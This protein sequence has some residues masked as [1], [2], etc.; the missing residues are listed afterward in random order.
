ML[1]VDV[2]AVILI[3][4]YFWYM[5]WSSIQSVPQPAHQPIHAKPVSTILTARGNH[6]R[7]E[8]NH[9]GW[10]TAMPDDYVLHDDKIVQQDGCHG[11]T[12][13]ALVPA[14]GQSLYRY[15][16]RDQ[17]IQSLQPFQSDAS[18]TLQDKRVFYFTCLGGQIHQLHKCPPGQI[19]QNDRCQDIN[20]CV[21]QP[22]GTLL[23]D[24]F[25]LSVYYV[26]RRG[27]AII[28]KCDSHEFFVNDQCMDHDLYHYCKHDQEPRI[29]SHDTMLICRRGHVSYETCPPGYR[30]FDSPK[31]ESD[32]CVGQPD[33]RR[34]PLPN[35][36]INSIEYAPG[37]MSCKANKVDRIQ[38]CPKYW[39][40]G[41]DRLPF[42]PQVFNGQECVPPELC[43]NVV[44]TDPDITMPVFE[45]TKDVRNWK[46]ASRFDQVTGIV[47]EGGAR[48]RVAMDPGRRINKRLKQESACD[49]E[50][51]VVVS[52]KTNAYYDC[53]TQAVVNCPDNHFFNGLECKERNPHAFKYNG[54]DMF[55]M[56]SLSPD[57][58]I[59]PWDYYGNKNEII[60]TCKNPDLILN[61]N[62]NVC[63][64]PDCIHFP[65]LSQ[66]DFTIGLKDG[67]ECEYQ[68][69]TREIIKIQTDKQ[70]LFWSQRQV[71]DPSLEDDCTPNQN[72]KSG[73]FAFDKT[74]FA[75]C[76]E[77]QP[78][79]FCPSSDTDG[80]DNVSKRWVC[81]AQ[82]MAYFV[83]PHTKRNYIKNEAYKITREKSAS[84]YINKLLIPI[85]EDGLDVSTYDQIELETRVRGVDVHVRRVTHPPDVAIRKGGIA[86][87]PNTAYLMKSDGFTKKAL[88]FPKYSVKGCVPDFLLQT[89]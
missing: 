58:W 13:D 14:V 49:T 10:E 38:T 85:P 7:F 78:F 88:N 54:L 84:V 3:L 28:K 46:W 35:E 68:E 4:L 73:H 30:Y 53:A 77:S 36:S 39:G 47:C 57:N 24:A 86:H 89:R 11:Q 51:R 22:D 9:T 69:S 62:Y 71:D 79:V 32:A 61:T 16:Q 20:L 75:T 67:S 60:D 56:D 74:I 43:T 17:F 1:L 8:M 66:I 25:D 80:I 29:L 23:N 5:T 59:K 12:D 15:L 34:L 76:D 50:T 40:F 33:G 19:F 21:G 81:K 72:I 44:P 42:L 18:I 83:P 65:F 2:I 64:H 82:T 31:C 27:V 55:V 37:F 52:G 41:V 63:I 70:Y 48:K 45:F 26:C 6:L 87:V